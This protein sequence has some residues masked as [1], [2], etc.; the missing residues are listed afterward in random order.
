MMLWVNLI[1][2]TMGALALGTEE[3][4]LE[5]LN[6]YACLPVD[7]CLALIVVCSDGIGVTDSTNPTLPTTQ[8]QPPLQALRPPAL[9]PHDPQHRRCVRERRGA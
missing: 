9:P 1:M 8:S 3:P 6:R 2:D 4:T 7:V 5:L